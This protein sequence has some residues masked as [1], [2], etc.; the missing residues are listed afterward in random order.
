MRERQRWQPEED[1]L[2][3]EYVKQYGAKE[4]ALVSE[5]MG[6]PLHRDPKS[7][8]E[9]WKN[10]LR[11][12]L[13]KGS[14]SPDEQSL[15]ISLQARYGNKWK[16]IAAH[17]PGRTP[18]R[19]GKWW[20]V[21]KEKQLKL[22]S[23]SS[24]SSCSSSAPFAFPGHPAASA[25]AAVSPSAYEHILQT[26]A[27]KHALL[28]DCSSPSPSS[29]LSAAA[30]AAAPSVALSLSPPRTPEL[31]PHQVPI[32]M[33]LCEDVEEGRRAWAQHRKEAAWRLSRL[34]QQMETEKARKKR[35]K[36]EEVEAKIRRLREE[37]KAWLE[38]LD[39]ELREKVT[40]LRMEVEE[41]EAKM[42]ESLSYKHAKLSAIIQRIGGA[43]SRR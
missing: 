5:R 35:E 3:R 14:L 8:H 9:R 41:D 17:L 36:V 37:E 15:L 30:P 29:V 12:G 34:E 27:E 19:L 31:A 13:K 40:R 33:R 42:T 1:A 18:K 23:L 16:A 32:L 21:F 6:R 2:L 24:T 38:R 11:P 28:G 39:V 43:R 4:W 25:A 10:Y 20:E 22:A 7:C 26:F